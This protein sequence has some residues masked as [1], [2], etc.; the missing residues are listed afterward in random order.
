M[1]LLTFNVKEILHSLVIFSLIWTFYHREIFV[2]LCT[3]N[4]LTTC[5]NY[6]LSQSLA[7]I[8]TDP[9]RPTRSSEVNA[10]GA[11][12]MRYTIVIYIYDRAKSTDTAGMIHRVNNE[13][14]QE[15]AWVTTLRRRTWRP[16]GLSDDTRRVINNMQVRLVLKDDPVIAKESRICEQTRE[17]RWAQVEFMLSPSFSFFSKRFP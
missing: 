14:A 4:T 16:D 3:N 2:I 6:S 15:F 13:R 12:S 11:K 7:H 10:T 9:K 5:D 8:E 1:Q 17:I